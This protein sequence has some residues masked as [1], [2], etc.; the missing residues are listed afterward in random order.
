[1]TESITAVLRPVKNGESAA[2]FRAEKPDSLQPN[3]LHHPKTIR[4]RLLIYLTGQA[5][6]TGS[7]AF[8]I[9]F[10]RQ[11]MADYLNLDRSALSKELGKMRK[12]GILDFHKNKFTLYQK[13]D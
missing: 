1:M 13:L 12:E 11:G 9:P 10:D 8:E 4:E 2:D 7:T 6:R 3:F 5:V